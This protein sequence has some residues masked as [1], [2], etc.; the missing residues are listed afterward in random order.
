MLGQVHDDANDSRPPNP[1]RLWIRSATN[2][3][4][5]DE[6]DFERA[7]RHCFARMMD[8]LQRFL[9]RPD[10]AFLAKTCA[11]ML[12]VCQQLFV[13]I[14]ASN[15]VEGNCEGSAS[16][17]FKV[18]QKALKR[19]T[20]SQGFCETPTRHPFAFR[21]REW[22]FQVRTAIWFHLVSCLQVAPVIWAGRCNA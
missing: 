3:Q 13:A 1:A 11:V 19:M 5:A 10:Q 12:Q 21:A 22:H 15:R 9:M 20:G 16:N 18:V 14:G 2:V 8:P 17:R 6:E 4:R 7:P